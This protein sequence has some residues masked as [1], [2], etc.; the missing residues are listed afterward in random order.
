MD[1]LERGLAA[2]ASTP[3]RLITTS[4]PSTARCT[5]PSMVTEAY[6]GTTCPTAP[7]GF[8][9]NALSG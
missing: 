8:R 4:A 6:N 1:G 5:V 7:I 3:T 9:N 2:S